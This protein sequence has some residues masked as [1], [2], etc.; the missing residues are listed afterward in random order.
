MNRAVNV[1]DEGIIL[2]GAMRIMHGQVPHADF[3]TNYGPGM[4]LSLAGLFSLFSPSI[5]T[6]RAFDTAVRALIAVVCFA[7]ARKCRLGFAAHLAYA[8]ALF[9][10][11]LAAFYGSASFPALLCI[12]LSVHALADTSALEKNARAPFLAGLA[13]GLATVFR[14]DFGLAALGL[15]L[16]FL[17]LFSR[18]RRASDP[19]QGAFLRRL[20]LPCLLGLSVPVLP[21][22]AV[23]AARD[24]FPALFF[25]MWRFPAANYL[26]MRGLPFPGVWQ[27]RATPSDILVYFPPLV[28]GIVTIHLLFKEKTSLATGLGPGVTALVLRQA[29]PLLLVSLSM[30]LFAKGAVRVS[31]LHM[32]PSVVVA[33]LALAFPWRDALKSPG[34]RRTAVCILWLGLA[35]RLGV[36]APVSLAALKQHD[37]TTASQSLTELL[38]P[39]LDPF[40]LSQHRVRAIAYIDAHLDKDK[41]LFVATGR[42]D[43]VFINDLAFYFLADRLPATK[44]AHYDPGLQTS[45]AVQENMVRELTEADVP[46]VVVDTSFDTVREPNASAASSGVTVLDAFLGRT[47]SPVAS[48]GPL[49]VLKKNAAP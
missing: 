7:I 3:Y 28:W 40:V 22:L 30:V 6:E 1:Y 9:V 34:L 24:A 49:T 19:E 31:L 44:W 29:T 27:L 47:Y 15:E 13:L 25:D 2:V 4:Y 36:V 11:G 37:R 48:F 12:L 46:Y 41:T 10:L 18:A 17:F 14:Y 23:Y 42:H 33:G 21:M 16:C 8:L 32:A 45:L 43:K 39:R 5:L 38:P 20:L 35:A 26:R